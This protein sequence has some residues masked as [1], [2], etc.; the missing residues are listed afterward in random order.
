M[1]SLARPY[2]LLSERAMILDG[3]HALFLSNEA[4]CIP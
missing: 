3:F 4:F 2:S 1:P